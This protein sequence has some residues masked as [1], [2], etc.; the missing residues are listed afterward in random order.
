MFNR[1]IM[2][3]KIRTIIDSN[4]R[5]YTTID[6]EEISDKQSV[7]LQ[8]KLDNEQIDKLLDNKLKKSKKLT[9]DALWAIADDM[10][11]RK[12]KGEFDTYRL[13]YRWAVKNYRK[14]NS[15]ITVSNLERAW[16]KAKCEGKVGIKKERK[17]SVPFMIT[18]EMRMRL[19]TLKYS[20]DDIKHL[21]PEEANDIIK[22]MRV[23]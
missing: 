1:D 20:N 22:E 16:H 19:R 13:A 15:I 2:N 14:G 18:Q 6:G 21:T 11:D 4:N 10:R 23:N 5:V 7:L 17:V 8:E 12:D 9:N 3:K